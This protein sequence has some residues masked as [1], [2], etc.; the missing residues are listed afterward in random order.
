MDGTRYSDLDH[1][2]RVGRIGC[3]VSFVAQRALEE[4]ETRDRRYRVFGRPLVLLRGNPALAKRHRTTQR[5]G[6]VGRDS[7]AITRRESHP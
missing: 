6:V 1:H 2:A 5:S 7:T 4:L 3:L